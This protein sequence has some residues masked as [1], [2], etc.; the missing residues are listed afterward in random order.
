[1]T[2]EPAFLTQAKDILSEIQIKSCLQSFIESAYS[3]PQSFS[4]S[5]GGKQL[6]S[7]CLP[8]PGKIDYG[9]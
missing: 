8:R 5:Q 3:G 7:S 9:V 6:L 4:A 1:M 2:P